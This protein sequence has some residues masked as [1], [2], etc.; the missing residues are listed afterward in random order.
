MHYNFKCCC[1]HF[2]GFSEEG[3]NAWALALVKA[4]AERTPARQL[5]VGDAMTDDAGSMKINN[6]V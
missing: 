5:L 2:L 6:R 4:L 3:M 1:C